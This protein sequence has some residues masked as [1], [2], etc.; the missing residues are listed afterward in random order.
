MQRGERDAI[1]QYRLHWRCE[2]VKGASDADYRSQPGFSDRL[3]YKLARARA[4]QVWNFSSRTDILR[5]HIFGLPGC[6]GGAVRF[7][8]K[9]LLR[10]K[11]NQ[12]LLVEDKIQEGGKREVDSMFGDV[13]NTAVSLFYCSAPV[14]SSAH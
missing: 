4:R 7:G 8:G 10:N 6:S 3:N 1:G 11:I 12:T 9:T 14:G 5:R 2:G 13:A